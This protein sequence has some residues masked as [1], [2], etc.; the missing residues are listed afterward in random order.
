MIPTLPALFSLRV[1]DNLEIS[2]PYFLSR[3]TLVFCDQNFLKIHQKNANEKMPKLFV[4]SVQVRPNKGYSPLSN[5][6]LQ[7]YARAQPAGEGGDPKTF[8]ALK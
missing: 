2:L 4:L 8:Y 7:D 3:L 1:Q 5:E 6:G